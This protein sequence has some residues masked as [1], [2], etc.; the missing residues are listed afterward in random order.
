MNEG[1]SEKQLDDEEYRVLSSTL[2]AHHMYSSWATRSIVTP[3]KHKYSTLSDREKSLLNWFPNYLQQLEH[4]IEINSRFFTHVADTMG[5]QWGGGER[6]N[7]HSPSETDL[8]KIRGL[9]TQYVRE[10]SSDGAKERD[11]SMGRI[12]RTAERVFPDI[13]SRPEVH[14]LVP[15]SGLGRLVVEFVKR[16]F[17]T[18]GNEISYHML[19]NCNYLLS[20]TYCEN[21]F[22]ICPFI[23]KSSN[24]DKRNFQCRQVQFPD[25]CPG[26]ISLLN[27]EYPEINVQ[28]LMSMVSGGFVDLYGP[29]NIET[30]SDMYTSDSNASEFRKSN[31]GKFKIVA[32]SFFIDTASNIIEYLETIKHCLDKDGYW[33]NFGPL[34]WHFENDQTEIDVNSINNNGERN[35]NKIPL[36]G[37][38]I[39]KEDLL[40]LISD[41]GFEFIEHES[42]IETSYGGDPRALGN[43]IYKCEFWVCKKI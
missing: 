20:D 40:K 2:S 16:G 9:M 17:Q 19:L 28:E 34:L 33:I 7:W 37:L 27:I 39:S 6:E 12:L 38:E 5:I 24:V 14:V 35:S 22:A 31:E 13:K 30:I 41:V 15:G 25:F 18:Q 1:Y 29:P 11:I 36:Q 10:W 26:D 32:T 42:N 43:W 23:H 4:S 21:N 8:D 3:K